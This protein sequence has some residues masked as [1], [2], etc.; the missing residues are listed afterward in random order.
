ML[1]SLLSCMSTWKPRVD[2]AVW[3]SVKELGLAPF[4]GWAVHASV[5][6]GIYLRSCKL[7]ADRSPDSHLK[8]LP[9]AQPFPACGE[10]WN[11]SSVQLLLRPSWK[12]MQTLQAPGEHSTRKVKKSVLLV[13][14]LA[15]LVGKPTAASPQVNGLQ[16]KLLCV[17]FL[18]FLLSS[19]LFLTPWFL[20]PTRSDPRMGCCI[21]NIWP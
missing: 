2:L 8:V 13:C 4:C 19:L 3:Y 17:I 18:G 16:W 10:S 1:V 15:L 7:S 6:Q 12:H 5:P 14:H 20:K 21:E 11:V 9:A